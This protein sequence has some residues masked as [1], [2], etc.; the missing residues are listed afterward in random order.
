M[1]GDA[2]QQAPANAIREGASIDH[3]FNGFWIT[4]RELH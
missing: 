4:R 2:D 1:I 3:Q